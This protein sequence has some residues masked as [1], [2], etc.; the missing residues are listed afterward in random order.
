MCVD[1]TLEILPPPPC[2]SLFLPA[3]WELGSQTRDAP[4]ARRGMS[5]A[6]IPPRAAHRCHAPR[7][8]AVHYPPVARSSCLPARAVARRAHHPPYGR[9]ALRN[10]RLSCATAG[11]MI[12]CAQLPVV[13]A[14]DTTV[15]EA[16]HLGRDIISG[17]ARLC[18]LPAAL[19]TGDSG[20]CGS[21]PCWVGKNSRPSLDLRASGERNAKHSQDSY[22]AVLVPGASRHPNHN[23]QRGD[24]I[25]ERILRVIQLLSPDAY[26]FAR[27]R[28]TSYEVVPTPSAVG[29]SVLP[30]GMPPSELVIIWRRVGLSLLLHRIDLDVCPS[31]EACKLGA[32]RFPQVDDAA[33]A[34][35]R[36][37]PL[38]EVTLA[39]LNMRLSDSS[40]SGGGSGGS[41]DDLEVFSVALCTPRDISGTEAAFAASPLPAFPSSDDWVFAASSFLRTRAADGTW[42]CVDPPHG[43]RCWR[44]KDAAIDALRR[45]QAQY[46]DYIFHDGVPGQWLDWAAAKLPANFEKDSQAKDEFHLSPLRLPVPGEK[47]LPYPIPGQLAGS[48]ISADW[49]DPV[50]CSSCLKGQE[51]V[52]TICREWAEGCIGCSP[53]P[54]GRCAE[55]TASRAELEADGEVQMC[56]YGALSNC[57]EMHAC[58]TWSGRVD[59]R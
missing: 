57:R 31:W 1:A 47:P 17:R 14:V 54:H 39:A 21:E 10:A 28:A 11:A 51:Y 29:P 15:L 56:Q 6:L 50:G 26:F 22:A 46:P 9:Q 24:L 2:S 8:R 44:T 40:S 5:E 45:A 55:C 33:R 18:V 53:T 20:T 58:S 32:A 34:A 12:L 19:I 27:E 16:L 48:K 25:D 42:E 41:S 3:T 38:G 59:P 52:C 49:P 30:R 13:H 7:Y 35:A 23:G 36:A 37:K 4:L 43:R